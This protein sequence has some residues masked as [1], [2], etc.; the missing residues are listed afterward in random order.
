ML[1]G[2]GDVPKAIRFYERNGFEIS[3][4]TPN[5]FTDNYEHP[6]FE[7]G[8]QLVDMV[9]LKRN[10]K[11]YGKQRRQNI[12]ENALTIYGSFIKEIKDLIYR[13]QYEVMKKVK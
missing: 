12:M 5:F 11:S 8:F 4:K 9:Y 3:H 6:M 2:T 1:V 10:L 7:D 13:R